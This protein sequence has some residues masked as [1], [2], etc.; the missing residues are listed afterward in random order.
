VTRRFE[1]FT[2]RGTHGGVVDGEPDDRSCAA[3]VVVAK[4]RKVK[5]AMSEVDVETTVFSR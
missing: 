3:S 2:D 5:A 4:G 1:P